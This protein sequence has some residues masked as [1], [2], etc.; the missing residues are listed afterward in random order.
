MDRQPYFVNDIHV[1]QLQELEAARHERMN[2]IEQ[3][4]LDAIARLAMA[5]LA[6]FDVCGWVIEKVQLMQIKSITARQPHFIS[7][8]DDEIED[9][10]TLQ[11]IEAAHHTKIDTFEQARLDMIAR[12]AIS[13]Y[14]KASK[15]QQAQ[16]RSIHS[17][18]LNS[19]GIYV[20]PWDNERILWIGFFKNNTN[21]KCLIHLLPKDVL[22]YIVQ[23][24]CTSRWGN[25]QFSIELKKT[26]LKKTCQ[27]N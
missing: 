3:G 13:D 12:L 10:R 9:I 25:T 18:A 6:S 19:G 24:L 26:V 11:Q 16:K 14:K 17:M 8:Y 21:N 5:D 7:G 4:R 23:F 2:T 22:I 1:R 20:D 15:A 27:V